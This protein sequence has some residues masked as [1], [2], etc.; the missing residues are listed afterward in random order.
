VRAVQSSR[1][2]TTEQ[3]TECAAIHRASTTAAT[4]CLPSA[5]GQ[6]PSA[7]TCWASCSCASATKPLV[8]RGMPPEEAE[9]LLLLSLLLLAVLV[10][11]AA[12]AS[13]PTLLRAPRLYTGGGAAGQQDIQSSGKSAHLWQWCTQQAP[14]WLETA[15]MCLAPVMLPR[16]LQDTCARW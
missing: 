11:A 4:A 16:Q 13:L 12:A 5:S 10:D 3:R 9:L 15:A 6:R 7:A 8:G 1:M 14:C 2:I